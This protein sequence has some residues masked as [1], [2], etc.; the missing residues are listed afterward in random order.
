[1]SFSLLNFNQESS[2]TIR[3]FFFG[4]FSA[5][6]PLD[7]LFDDPI[8]YAEGSILRIPEEGGGEAS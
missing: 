8:V 7:G 5:I 3:E 1:M 6:L 2:I 4:P